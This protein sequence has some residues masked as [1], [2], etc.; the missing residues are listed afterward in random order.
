MICF[1][2]PLAWIPLKLLFCEK[3]KLARVLER[4][5]TGALCLVPPCRVRDL[6]WGVTLLCEGLRVR[7]ALLDV[8]E[9]AGEHRRGLELREVLGL[10]LGL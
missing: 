1:F 2:L 10:G 5:A 9:Q 6:G 8:G 7:W 3:R 4:F